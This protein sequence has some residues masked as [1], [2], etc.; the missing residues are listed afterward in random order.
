V[1]PPVTTPPT[2]PPDRPPVAAG[3]HLV[4]AQNAA[5]HTVD[6]LA[7]DR[8][9]DHDPLKVAAVTQPAHGT[10][11][12]TS[13][14]VSYSPDAGYHGSDSFR[15]TVSDGRGGTDTATVTVTVTPAPVSPSTLYLRGGSSLLTT[16]MTTGAPTEP[17]TDWDHDGHPGLTIKASDLKPTEAD[18]HKFQTW[19]WAVPSGGLT[20]HGPMSL[21]LWSSPRFKSGQDVDYS[22]WVYSCDGG[23]A[24]CQLLT[25][26]VKVH[27]AKWS[28]TTS[29]ERRTISLGSA[30]AT[31]APGRTLRVRLAFG[32]SDIWLPLDQAH[33]SSLSFTT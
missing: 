30:S 18:T 15:Y 7:N 26:A 4:L 22:A 27:V 13:G 21:S 6:V 8:D 25:S 28:S 2:P 9:P 5:A 12:H 23:G 32:K 24:S 3:D 17:A 1:K 31:M 19:S 16:P 20:L 11:K 10:A 29:W 33:P 14:A